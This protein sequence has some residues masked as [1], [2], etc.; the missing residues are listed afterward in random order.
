L[1]WSMLDQASRQGRWQVTNSD[2]RNRDLAAG[3]LA[4]PGGTARVVMALTAAFA[5]GAI[6]QYLQVAISISSQPG[7]Y[8]F[9]VQVSNGMSAPWLLVPFLAGA[10][11]ADRL[12]AAVVGL[13][14]TWL[15]VLAYVLMV[16][17][18]M[19]GVHLTPRALAFS[20][21]SQW[22]WFAG[23]LITGPLFGWL[24]HRWRARQ[25]PAVALLVALPVLLEPCA[26]WLAN[27][28]GLGSVPWIPFRWPLDAGGVT[29]EF[30]EL[31]VGLLLTCAVIRVVV[32]D[33]DSAR[34]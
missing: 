34:A 28:L 22:P 15:S 17:S 4:R 16:V 30:A 10:W 6:D 27:G 2:W 14:A 7:A 32:R 1:L 33:R 13:V 8:Q 29:A 21:A 26:R 11:Q 5:F 9:A 20:L 23:G 24:G 25:S 12:R 31:T 19:E 3:A 18:P